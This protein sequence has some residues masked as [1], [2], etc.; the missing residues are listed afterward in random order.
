MHLNRAHKL[1]QCLLPWSGTDD[2][3]YASPLPEW[4]QEDW[5]TTEAYR[6]SGY[7]KGQT[8]PEPA[9]PPG[10]VSV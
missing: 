1:M 8:F 10:R 3:D 4:A 7:V 2:W 5:R 6:R 9:L